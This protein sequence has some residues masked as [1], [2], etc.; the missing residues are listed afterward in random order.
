MR[1]LWLVNVILPEVSKILNEKPQPYGGWLI[2]TSKE[3]AIADD[4]ELAI[5]FPNNKFSELTVINGDRITY[6]GF[7]LKNN[8]TYQLKK[9]ESTFESVLHKFKPDI[10]HIFGTEYS[11]ALAMANACQQVG[12]DHVVSIQGLVSEIGK[13]YYSNLPENVI[14]GNTLR[15]F[16]KRDGLFKLKK[17]FIKK[18]KFEIDL[19]KKT[20]YVIGRTTWDK[21]CVTQI[22]PNITYYRCNETLRDTF[23]DE[24]WSINE[25]ITHSIFLSQG[26][27]PIKG[28]HYVIDALKI[29]KEKYPKTKLFIG[30]RNIFNNNTLRDKLK[31]TYYGKYLLDKIKVSKLEDTVMFLGELDESEIAKMYKKSN[32]FV[33]SSSIE[34]SPNSLGEAMILGVPCVASHVGGIPDLIT[35]GVEGFLYQHN[36]SRMLAY[37]IMNIFSD[38]AL[39]LEL[40]KNA[41]LRARIT[42]DKETNLNDLKYIYKELFI[43]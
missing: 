25:C 30:G 18:G 14:H 6:F 22:N 33:C 16:V 24:Q 36:D 4:V 43:K 20:R 17:Q 3:L 39:A 35:H 19:L 31:L 21:A 5:A 12:I 38:D 10:V 11:Y 32:V 13:H 7:C 42:H 27:Y 28:L 40:S 29:V 8:K 37:H 1:V 41:K 2:N 9:Y 34:N 15:N 26:H 23:Y